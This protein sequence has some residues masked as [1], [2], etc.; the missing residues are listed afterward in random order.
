MF[1]KNIRREGANAKLVMAYH[2]YQFNIGEI[3]SAAKFCRI[4]GIRF[5][6]YVAY[7]ADYNLARA[8]LDKSVSK[9]ILGEIAKDLF[10]F[11]IDEL[12]ANI[13]QNYICP[14]FNILTIDENCNILTCCALPKDHPE[15]LIVMRGNRLILNLVDAPNPAY[16]PKE[17][18][19]AALAFINTSLGSG[20]RVL[21]HCNE[22]CS[23]SAGI[24]LLYLAKF[25]DKIPKATFLE[26]E[27]LYRSIYP[28]YNPKSGMR[29]FIIEN[30]KEY[31]QN[32]M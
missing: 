21:V 24:G 7:L 19:D 13:P 20:S 11:Y 16:I 6:P 25:T 17:I 12:R 29:G 28:P 3:S 9:E 1:C 22:G 30:W 27:A 18:I 14:Q 2:I 31:A 32:E 8:Y 23:R 5:M 26:A 10:L 15:Y 4:N